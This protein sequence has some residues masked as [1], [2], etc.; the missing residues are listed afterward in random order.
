MM[1]LVHALGVVRSNRVPGRN[2][3]GPD[4]DVATAVEKFPAELGRAFH[5]G[6]TQLDGD[7]RQ[8]EGATRDALE[9]EDRL[10]RPRAGRIAWG[11]SLCGESQRKSKKSPPIPFAPSRCAMKIYSSHPPW[12]GRTARG[13]ARLRR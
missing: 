7:M 9:F 5:I 12:R 4:S 2:E 3:V 11:R 6:P 13:R 8:E 10:G 1:L